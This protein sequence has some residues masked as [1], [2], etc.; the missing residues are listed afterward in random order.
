[1]WGFGW[2]GV[3]RKKGTDIDDVQGKLGGTGG[4]FLPCDLQLDVAFL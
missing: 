3:I 4:S 1:M 2:G